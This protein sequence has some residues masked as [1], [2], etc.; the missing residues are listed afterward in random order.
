MKVHFSPSIPMQRSYLLSVTRFNVTRYQ[1][2]VGVKSLNI[3]GL[4]GSPYWLSGIILLVPLSSNPRS[5]GG[6]WSLSLG[7]YAFEKVFCLD[8]TRVSV[9]FLNCVTTV[10]V[11]L[12]EHEG[13]ETTLPQQGAAAALSRQHQ[14]AACVCEPTWGKVSMHPHSE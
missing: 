12:Y 4:S 7:D 14:G 13:A 2:D 1:H 3:L 8:Q 9:R 5:Q 6:C 11:V 10:T